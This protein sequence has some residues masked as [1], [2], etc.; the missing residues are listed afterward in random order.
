MMTGNFFF[1]YRTCL[2]TKDSLRVECENA[3]YL[4]RAAKLSEK[5][6]KSN[7]NNRMKYV[8]IITQILTVYTSE[9]DL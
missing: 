6:K 3:S 9:E 8:I 5:R 2:Q 1:M 7:M 4:Q